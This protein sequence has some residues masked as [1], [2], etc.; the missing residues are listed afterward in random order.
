MTSSKL[1]RKAKQ[2]NLNETEWDDATDE[3]EDLLELSHLYTLQQ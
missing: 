2:M 3:D 1:L